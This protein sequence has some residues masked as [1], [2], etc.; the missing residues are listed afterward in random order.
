[1]TTHR[2]SFQHENIENLIPYTI[3]EISRLWHDYPELSINLNR[4]EDTL[5]KNL[6]HQRQELD[7]RI[8]RQVEKLW[9]RK[10]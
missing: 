10:Q 9:K 4:I 8:N 5:L 1:M 3:D 6:L 2:V 7:Y